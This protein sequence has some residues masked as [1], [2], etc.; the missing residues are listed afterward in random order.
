ML[1]SVAFTQKVAEMAITAYCH[2][3]LLTGGIITQDDGAT[4][5]VLCSFDD[6]LWRDYGFEIIKHLVNTFAGLNVQIFM[7]FSHLIL[8]CWDLLKCLE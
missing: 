6:I 3:A 2:S 5:F 4:I 7:C 8:F 1:T